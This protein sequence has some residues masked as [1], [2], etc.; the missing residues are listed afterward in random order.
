M[1]AAGQLADSPAPSRKRKKAKLRSPPASEVSI[2]AI[3]YQM[4]VTVSPRRVPTR[5][6]MRPETVCPMEYATRK[7]M[8][9][10][11]NCSLLHVYSCFR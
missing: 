7:A 2:A 3:E 10:S 11:A 6:M 4:T 1:V 5:S 8:T 9:I